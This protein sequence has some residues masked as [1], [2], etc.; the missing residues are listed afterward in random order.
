MVMSVATER[1]EEIEIER[2]ARAQRITQLLDSGIPTKDVARLYGISR[3]GVH[4]VLDIR[5]RVLRWSLLPRLRG[6]TD[7]H[8]LSLIQ[9]EGW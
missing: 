6:I 8:D 4:T 9:G 1:R 5:E 2:E 3:Q 7:K